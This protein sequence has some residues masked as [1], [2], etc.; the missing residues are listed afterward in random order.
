MGTEKDLI[1]NSIG[2]KAP[3]L[4]KLLDDLQSFIAENLKNYPLF[5]KPD[6]WEDQ[7]LTRD[8]EVY[9]MISPESDENHE[10][11]PYILL[12]L[13]NGYDK[14]ENNR[15]ISKANIR[16]VIVVYNTDKQD[17]RLQI[18]RIIQKI[19]YEILSAGIIGNMFKID[20]LE[21]LIY[22]DE[23]EWYHMGEM[24]T[25]WIIPSVERDLNKWN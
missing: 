13:L 23:I 25:E 5:I 18:L 10:K 20:G 16:L 24:S 4:E 19:R 11:I 3:T 8:V 7:A 6:G 2:V 15:L 9:Q 12:Q 17:G 22:P 1:K 21:Y 14:K